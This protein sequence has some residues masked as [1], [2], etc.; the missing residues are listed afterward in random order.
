MK[1]GFR[2][3]LALLIALALAA[4]PGCAAPQ[5]PDAPAKPAG[6]NE[7]YMVNRIAYIDNRGDLRLIDPDGSG[8]ERLTG[9]FRA[10]L[11]AQALDPG[12]S[13]SWPTWRRDGETVATSRVSIAGG[14]AGLSV[15]LFDLPAGRMTSA[16][17]NDIPAPVADGA[18]HYIYWSPDGRYLTFLAPT[19]DGLALFVRDYESDGEPAAVAVGAPLYYHWAPSSRQMAVHTGNRLMLLLP[20]PAG[21]QT[22]MEHTYADVDAVGFR[23]PAIS[24]AGNLVAYA[25]GQGDVHGVFIRPASAAAPRLPVPTSH[26]ITETRGMTAFAWAPDRPVLAVSEAAPGSPVFQRLSLYPIDGSP[27]SLILHEPHLAFFW[28]PKGDRIAWIG[29]DPATRQMELSVSP[30][31][32]DPGAGAWYNGDARRLFRFSPT[33]EFFT[34]LS[35]FDQYA[36]SHSLWSPDGSA[37]VITGS[38]GPESARRNGSAPAGGQVYVIDADTGEARPIASGNMAVWSWN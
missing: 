32:I 11:P 29:V 31:P 1:A 7:S 22:F 6:G 35:F 36:Y 37:L 34:W 3:L 13:Y 2:Q 30:T 10:A 24:P 9:D 38:Q 16:Y 19:P 17:D 18:P 26:L 23:A 27:P 33:G 12:D 5:P 14:N 4:L 21:R 20:P 25:A 8:E 28:S 15:Q